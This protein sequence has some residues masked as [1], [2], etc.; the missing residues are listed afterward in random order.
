V[1]QVG[2]EV[3]LDWSNAWNNCIPAPD[4]HNSAGGGGGGG[5]GQLTMVQQRGM[6]IVSIAKNPPVDLTH[7][8]Q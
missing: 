8:G 2:P 5:A 7:I 6:N 4:V 3:G 1:E